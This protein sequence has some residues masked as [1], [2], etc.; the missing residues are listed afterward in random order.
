MNCDWTR[1]N[2]VLYIYEELP[3]DAKF[4]FER[5]IQHC[6]SCRRE[7]ES[8]REFKENMA[9]FPVQEISP[10]LLA[11]NRM[12]LQEALEHAE[13]SRGWG[14]FVFDFAGW[15]HQ[16][17][18]APALT[19][20]LLIFGFAGGVGTTYSILKPKG[21][22]PPPPVANVAGIESIIPQEN[23]N[24]VTIKY[25]TLMPQTTEG[26]I[27]DPQIQQLLLLAC[28]N[29]RDAGVRLV[30]IDQMKKQLN[31]QPEDNAVREAL[32]Y[33]LRYDQNPGVRLKA[34]DGLKGYVKDDRHVR[35]AV[36][37]ALMHDTNAGVR[38]EAISLLDQ[39][40]ADGNVRD[41]LR[42]LAE[43]DQNTY[44]RNESKRILGSTPNL[45]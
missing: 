27:N 33:A 37:E 2:V 23:S 30:C 8:A 35:D 24:K 18:L 29:N 11:A 17:K 31:A 41:T 15:M 42:V 13:Q 22:E 4:E 16:L 45:E 9:A 20:A 40:K 43:R 28:K 34:L 6:I 39:V 32:V 44:I 38:S 14:M 26:D 1:D 21:P 10:N 36:L 12:E 3:D 7:L 19:A 25:D 5:H